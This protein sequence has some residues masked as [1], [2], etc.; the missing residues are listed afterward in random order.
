[1]HVAVQEVTLVGSD[2]FFICSPVQEKK[3]KTLSILLNCSIAFKTKSSQKNCKLSGLIVNFFEVFLTNVYVLINTRIWSFY[4][5]QLSLF[6]FDILTMQL[7]TI[8]RVHYCYCF[9]LNFVS[10]FSLS[11]LNNWPYSFTSFFS[12]TPQQLAI[13]IH[14]FFL[15]HSSTTGH[16]HATG[17]HFGRYT[18]CTR[19]LLMQSNQ[20][21]ISHGL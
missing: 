19:F 1:M 15:C 4:N 7:S 9:N 5:Q 2:L 6:H 12:V 17:K 16:I 13:F 18:G 14:L 10:L 8:V 21:L 3:S 11:L 20:V